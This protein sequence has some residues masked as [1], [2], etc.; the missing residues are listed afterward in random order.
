MTVM[1]AIAMIADHKYQE[2]ER[3]K[4]DEFAWQWRAAGDPGGPGDNDGDDDG[5]TDL[6]TKTKP[7]TKKPSL[8]KV[9]ILN[10]DYTPQDFV[11]DVLQRFFGLGREDATRVML[12][13]HHKGAGICGVFTYEIAETKVTQVTDYARRHQH[14]LQCVMEKE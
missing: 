4:R 5:R 2:F 14:P 7:K 8:Y 3:A 1:T 13:V 10:D 12:H 9:L 11:V 6:I